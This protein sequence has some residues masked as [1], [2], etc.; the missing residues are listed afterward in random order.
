[1]SEFRR[2][3]ARRLATPAGLAAGVLAGLLVAV[4]LDRRASAPH[5]PRPEPTPLDI[6]RLSHA[7]LETL[8]LDVL[9]TLNEKREPAADG[10]SAA[11]K[12]PWDQTAIDLR[13]IH[14]GMSNVRRLLPLAKKLTLESLRDSLK[15]SRL[16]REK[17][18]VNSVRRIVLD[19]TLGNTAQVWEEDLSVIH[20]GPEYADSLTSDDDAML[21]LG[22]E[23]THV[24]ART[25]GLKHFVDAVSSTARQSA[26]LELDE[27][28]K[29]ELAC[30]FSGAEVL[31]RYIALHPTAQTNAERFSRAFGYE[32]HPE[33]LARAWQDF[34]ASYNGDPLDEVH[35]SQE[36]TFRALPGL[37]PELKA[38][39]PDDATSPRLCR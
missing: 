36:Q 5:E 39:I 17:R 35:L 25:G 3:V 16:S 38:L 9:T 15:T 4:P 8:A 2:K 37:D 11:V 30:D 27:E 22:H 18:L 6:A 34:C 33:R 32:P 1:M 23:L 10:E 31:K 26:D 28:Q 13:Q 21:M 19:P 20:V 14:L 29:E 12:S 7:E 24:A